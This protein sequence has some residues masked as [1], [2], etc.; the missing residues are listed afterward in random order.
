MKII[1]KL[2]KKI[3][4]QQNYE[5]YWKL[6]LGY[7]DIND[8]PFRETL[9]IIVDYIDAKGTTDYSPQI[10]KKLQ[11]EVNEA[12]PKNMAS[13]RKDINLFVK[14]GFVE[15]YL[16][17]YHINTKEFL[18]AK[19]NR[20]RK[21]VFSK[22]VYDN[23]SFNRSVT[24]ESNLHQLNFLINTLV[25][26]G[27]LS[28][29]EIIALMLVDIG[30]IKKGFLDKNELEH[31]LKI[32]IESEFIERKYNQIG[33]LNNI[34]NK[35]DE[36]VFVRDELYFSED[37]RRIFGEDLEQE[38][39]KRN[40]YLH[41]LYKRE[42]Y[43]ESSEKYQNERTCYF[44]KRIYPVVI[45]SHIKPFIESEENEAYDP[46]N[47]LLLSP[48]IDSLFDGRKEKPPY[49]S[50]NDDGTIIF[51]ERLNEK[52]R[53]FWKDYRLEENI[54]NEKRKEYLAYHRN[55]MIEN[56]ANA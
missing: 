13:T 11:E 53:E 1:K 5:E 27:K 40:P 35:L 50:F 22:I 20:K 7:T 25:E 55:L 54:L 32:A 17:G 16:N 33:Y 24:N 26:N 30:N 29:S 9:K 44:E 41:L 19:S 37:A 2:L 21:T 14:L 43:E 45:A 56:N 8:R 46:N 49:L 10:Y 47:G 34:L 48:T 18:N 52:V 31:Y 3:M 15:S 4:Q 6:T 38:S 12:F 39:K 36:I 51:S 23:S 28:K 42:L